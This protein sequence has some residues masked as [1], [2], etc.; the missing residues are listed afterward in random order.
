[1]EGVAVKARDRGDKRPCELCSTKTLF[2][3]E[4]TG[5]RGAHK[6]WADV[7]VP[8]GEHPALTGKLK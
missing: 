6:R 5:K 4:V 1:V 7:C 8:C 2:V 3:F